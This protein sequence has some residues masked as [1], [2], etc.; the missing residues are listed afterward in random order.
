VPVNRL[1]ESISYS[2]G[3]VEAVFDIAD[4]DHVARFADSPYRAA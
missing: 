3:V 2:N 1:P 4:R